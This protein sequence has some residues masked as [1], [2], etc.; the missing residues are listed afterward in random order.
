MDR[1]RAQ[2]IVS[3]VFSDSVMVF[4]A[5]LV[6]PIII[7]QFVPL[8]PWQETILTVLDVFIYLM[9]LLEFVLKVLVA[10]DKKVYLKKHRFDAVISL[11]II[12]SPLLDL[13]SDVFR[14]VPLL[15]VFSGGSRLVRVVAVSGWA[16]SSWRRTTFQTYVAMGLIVAL[17]FVSSFFKPV[18]TLDSHDQSLFTLFIQIMGTLYAIIIGFVIANVWSKFT[19]LKS[20][21][22]QES[23]SLENAYLL[24]MSLSEQGFRARLRSTM[25]VYLGSLLRFFWRRGGTREEE[26]HAFAG[27]LRSLHVFK[28]ESQFE[29][30]VFDKIIDQV[31]DAAQFRAQ[32]HSLRTSKT[33]WILWLII[34]IISV[35]LSLSFYIIPFESQTISTLIL[36]LVSAIIALVAGMIY[37]MDNPFTSGFWIISPEPFLSLKNR[38]D[39]GEGG[40]V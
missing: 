28:S 29:I 38:L 20:L 6:I 26:D 7:A 1:T 36:T 16:R 22:Q 4:L 17:G 39:K 23:A 9:F 14:A 34:V 3:S 10:S 30:T 37:D 15:R 33:P 2:R 40:P 27:F 11:I 24:S 8:L 25:L 32:T 18:V 31:R 5:F 19:T 13:V 35:I 12:F 21:V